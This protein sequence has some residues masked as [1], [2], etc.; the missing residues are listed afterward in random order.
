M[1]KLELS[2]LRLPTLHS[3]SS[4]ALPCK[5]TRTF[6]FREIFKH[7]FKIYGIWP[8]AQ[9]YTH[10]SAQCSPASVG[11]AQ[12]R[13]NYVY[14]MQA[15][16]QYHFLGNITLCVS[17][18][19]VVTWWWMGSNTI[20]HDG[21]SYT[22]SNTNFS[23]V[24]SCS[25]YIGEMVAVAL[26]LGFSR[27][28]FLV[29]CTFAYCKQLKTRAGESLGVRLGRWLWL[30]AS[31]IMYGEIWQFMHAIYCMWWL[32]LQAYV[33]PHTQS[34]NYWDT[35]L[36]IVWWAQNMGL[37]GPTSHQVQWHYPTHTS[38]CKCAYQFLV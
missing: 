13:P 38:M 21:K 35:R 10:T 24:L 26:I 14:P 11:I 3:G 29:G 6:N 8:Q 22:W 33:L 9:S 20:S 19:C 31:I 36:N 34:P 5:C 1:L 23:V 25:A 17:V 4:P 32:H 12:A 15:T 37:C 2:P 18:T 7:A 27:L 28:Q 30:Q 16:Y